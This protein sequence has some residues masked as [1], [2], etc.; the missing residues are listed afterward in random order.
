VKIVSI[1]IK[2][3]ELIMLMAIVKLESRMSNPALCVHRLIRDEY[4]RKFSQ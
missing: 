2:D 4:R 3:D 1:R